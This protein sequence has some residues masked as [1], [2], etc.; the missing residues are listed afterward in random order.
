MT[1]FHF[2]I[3]G[4]TMGSNVSRQHRIAPVVLSLSCVRRAYALA[5]AKEVFELLACGDH[6]GK[7]VI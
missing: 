5:Y 7:I 6:L 2:L 1:A 3:L 4:S